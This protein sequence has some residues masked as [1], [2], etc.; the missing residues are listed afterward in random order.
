MCVHIH[1]DL[2]KVWH[3][4][5]HHVSEWWGYVLRRCLL[6]SIGYYRYPALV[7]P[8]SQLMFQKNLGMS[9]DDRSTDSSQIIQI[10]DTI[11]FYDLCLNEWTRENGKEKKDYF[12][13]PTRYKIKNVVGNIDNLIFIVKVTFSLSSLFLVSFCP[14]FIWLFRKIVQMVTDLLQFHNSNLT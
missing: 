10:H 8:P 14:N 2:L 4:Y 12:G 3:Y 6:I 5:Y 1:D 13:K 11:S 9:S 7:F